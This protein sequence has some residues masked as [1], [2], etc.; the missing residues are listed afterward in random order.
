[1]DNHE[2]PAALTRGEF[3][4]VLSPV[5]LLLASALLLGVAGI[6]P[7]NTLA[8]IG[9]CVLFLAALGLGVFCAIMGIRERRRQPAPKDDAARPSDAPDRG[10][11]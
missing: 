5:C 10:G 9:Y 2:K 8:S 7:Q 6:D 1:M 4:A 11:M 3:Y